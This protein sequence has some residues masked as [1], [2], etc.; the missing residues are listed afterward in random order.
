[1]SLRKVIFWLSA[2]LLLCSVVT[3]DVHGGD[4]DDDDVVYVDDDAAAGGNGSKKSPVQTIQEGLTLLSSSGGKVLVHPGIYI[5]PVLIDRDNVVIRGLAK[6]EYDS[7]GFLTGFKNGEEVVITID[8]PLMNEGPGEPEPDDIV[9]LRGSNNKVRNIVVDTAGFVDPNGFSSAFSAKAEDNDFYDDI[10][11]RNL[12]IRGQVPQAI[13]TRKANVRI[14]HVTALEGGFLGINP[15]AGGHVT[16]ENVDLANWFFAGVCYLGLWELPLADNGPSLITGTLKKSRITGLPVAFPFGW[17]LLL[18]GQ[19]I[20]TNPAAATTVEV[21][22][23]DNI[24][25]G[26][27][28]AI[29]VQPI[30]NG[31]INSAPRNIHIEVEDNSYINNVSDVFVT[32]QER[33][34]ELNPTFDFAVDATVTVDDKDG[35]FP[36]PGNVNLGPPVNNNH[37]ILD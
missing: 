8:M 6:P 27:R 1:M 4:D 33:L 14:T 10:V 12:L 22:A 21:E 31:G 32:F 5:G 29:R 17:G 25:Q 16:V 37:Y 20:A 35:V 24:F 26:N 15:T 28:Q 11:F 23:K 18:N 30:F 9:E 19:G 36:A 34:P 2:C 3:V 7:D 13:W